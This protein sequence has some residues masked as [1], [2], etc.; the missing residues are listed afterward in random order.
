[1]IG[2]GMESQSPR[3]ILPHALQSYA[4]EDVVIDD[5]LV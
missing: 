4:C 2:A 5:F 3:Q 1:M